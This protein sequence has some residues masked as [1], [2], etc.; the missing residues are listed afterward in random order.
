MWPLIP[1]RH[2]HGTKQVSCAI[3]RFPYTAQGA[4][5]QPELHETLPQKTK[6]VRTIRRVMNSKQ[7][8]RT[9]HKGAQQN[10]RDKPMNCKTINLQE[11]G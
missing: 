7:N 8:I 10:K 6:S 9:N 5:G 4:Q 11:N 1:A 2:S 3:S